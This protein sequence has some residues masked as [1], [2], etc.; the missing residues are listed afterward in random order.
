MSDRQVISRISGHGMRL[1]I[2]AVLLAVMLAGCF[3]FPVRA[4]SRVEV[5]PYAIILGWEAEPVIVGERNALIIEVFEGE[6]PVE[7]LEGTL[8]IQVLYAGR[9]FLGDLTPGGAPGRYRAE[10]FPTVRG[11]YE[12]RLTGTVEDMAVDEVLEPEEVLSAGVLQFPENQPDPI[13]QQAALASLQARVQTTSTLALA[14]VI[15]GLGGLGL[16]VFS[17]RRT[18]RAK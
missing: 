14:G 18:A 11:Q 5:G 3:Y 6:R 13:E 9:T 17:L 7:G 15:L 8:E 16:A 10:I 4:H 12:V 1:A 2:P